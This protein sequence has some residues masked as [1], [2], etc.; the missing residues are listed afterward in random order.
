YRQLII[1]H[2]K[3]P[4]NRGLLQHT[5]TVN[6]NN[7]TS[8]HPIQLTIKL[9]QPILQHPNFQP[10]PSSISIS[11]PSIITQPVKPNKIQQPLHLS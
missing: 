1:D 2:Y 10:Q 5:L 4:P 7:P 6:F 8:P 11:S 9:Q 3:N